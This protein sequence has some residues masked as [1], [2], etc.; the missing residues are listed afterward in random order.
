MFTRLSNLFLILIGLALIGTVL[1]PGRADHIADDL[2]SSVIVQPAEKSLVSDTSLGKVVYSS[3]VTTPYAP[4]ASIEQTQ[5]EK[6]ASEIIDA[7][8]KQRIYMGLTPL[9]VNQKLMQSAKI[10]TEDMLSKQYFEHVSPTGEDKS[11]LA[12]RVGYDY[13]VIGENLAFGDFENGE[14]I[15][16]AWMNSPGHRANI[17]NT[18]Y[19]EIGVY[20]Q[21]GMYQG[22]ERWFAVQ[23][24]GAPRTS[25]PHIDSVLGGA[26]SAIKTTLEQQKQRL[27]TEKDTLLGPDHPTGEEYQDRVTA[28]NLLVSQYNS[29]LS[30]SQEKIKTYNA[31]VNAFNTCQS[32]Y[33]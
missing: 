6:W 15:V 27:T 22:K 30:I 2:L 13:I 17:L 29:L 24:F 10:K 21:R 19:Q 25:C 14:D 18:H 3:L 31:Q 9:T 12:S 26:I 4:A 16:Q 33:E 5:A 28:F 20:A 23:H 11:T 7:T 8:N 32:E 1:Y